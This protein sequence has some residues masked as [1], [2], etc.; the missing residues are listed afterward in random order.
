M[1]QVQTHEQGEKFTLH[2]NYWSLK[3]HGLNT[4]STDRSPYT[5]LKNWL[6]EITFKSLAFQAPGYSY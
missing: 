5:L 3:P 2:A 4:N 1:A 6:R